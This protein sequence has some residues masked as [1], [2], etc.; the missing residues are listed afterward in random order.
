MDRPY[1][2]IDISSNIGRDWPDARG[3]WLNDDKT[4]NAL[5]NRRD[6]IAL[7]VLDKGTNLKASLA[8]LFHFVQQVCFAVYLF[9]IIVRNESFSFLFINKVRKRD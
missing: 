2:P 7:S 4:L 8:K 6:H 1:S 5:I 9:I 3:V